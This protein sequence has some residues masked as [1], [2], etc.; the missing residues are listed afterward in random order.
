MYASFIACR[1]AYHSATGLH[2]QAACLSELPYV[3]SQ[4]RLHLHNTTTYSSDS[5]T[6]AEASHSSQYITTQQ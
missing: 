6:L 5:K 4:V 1:R 3:L 2:V